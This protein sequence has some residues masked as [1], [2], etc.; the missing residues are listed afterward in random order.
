M[1]VFG[2]GR[3]GVWHGQIAWK[4]ILANLVTLD[5]EKLPARIWWNQL[6][7]F[8]FTIIIYIAPFSSQSFKYSFA[9]EKLRFSFTIQKSFE[10]SFLFNSPFKH[11]VF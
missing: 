9:L 1:F 5:R 10:L 6:W 7:N 11:P 8:M 3:N 2:F 4:N